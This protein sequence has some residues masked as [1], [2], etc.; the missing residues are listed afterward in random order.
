MKAWMSCNFG[1]ITPWAAEL[2]ALEC[3][4]N[5]CITLLAL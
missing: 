3:V 2:A 1:R 4:K 5:I